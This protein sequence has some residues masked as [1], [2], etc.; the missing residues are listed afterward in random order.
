MLQVKTFLVP[1]EQDSANEFLKTHKPMGQVHFNKDTIVIF[2]D[3]FLTTPELEI[4]D[5]Q[6]LIVA[7]RNAKFQQ[8]LALFMMKRELADTPSN[9][10]HYDELSRAI[11]ETEKALDAQDA[12]A[13]YVQAKIDVFKTN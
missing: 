9:L 2:Y 6:E 13:A 12:K 8:E 10:A 1:S 4:A 3:D 11:K 5:L 7:N